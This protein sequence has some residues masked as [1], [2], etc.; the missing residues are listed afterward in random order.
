[1]HHK[2]PVFDLAR[3]RRGQLTS[4]RHV[5]QHVTTGRITRRSFIRI[6]SAGCVFL[7][8]RTHAGS[9]PPCRRRLQQ[10]AIIWHRRVSVLQGLHARIARTGVRRRSKHRRGA[11]FRR[12]SVRSP[13]A[14]DAGV[15]C[16]LRGRHR[17]HRS[18]RR[19][20]SA[21]DANGSNRGSS[22]RTTRRNR[23]G[24]GS[25]SPGGGKM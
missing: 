7:A 3:T 24:C 21:C 6:T 16:G 17:S 5:G 23:S 1:M 22:D 15:G 8:G 13:A 2:P 20:G 9:L 4:E 11:T 18:G 14:A 10:C 25:G 19:R 12:R